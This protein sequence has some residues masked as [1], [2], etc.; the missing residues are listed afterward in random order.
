MIGNDYNKVGMIINH[1]PLC[2]KVISCNRFGTGTINETYLVKTECGCYILQKVND[3]IFGDVELLMQNIRLVLNSFKKDSYPCAEIILTKDG[4]LSY[5]V[6]GTYWR[7]YSYI[8]NTVSYDIVPNEQVAYQYGY[9]LGQLRTQLFKVDAAQL[10]TI[11]PNFHD[12]KKRFCEFLLA[13]RDDLVNRA[14]Q[15]KG[16]IEYIKQQQLFIQNVTTAI[17]NA[18]LKVC[19]IHN[20][21]RINNL[22]FREGEPVCFVDYD[23]ISR[24]LP[25]YDFCDAFRCACSPSTLE[26]SKIEDIIIDLKMIHHFVD[27]YYSSCAQL[28]VSEEVSLWLPTARMLLLENGMRM[29]TDYLNGDKYFKI[30]YG[31]HN[32]DRWKK[33]RHLIELFDQNV[34]SIANLLDKEKNGLT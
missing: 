24:G 17:E 30:N 22:L 12:T 34:E 29:L 7:L 2:G 25:L 9:A 1:F 33:H 3:A 11:I 26:S 31:I 14:S 32:L 18:Q 15:V 19:A 4:N 16:E 27:G 10:C 20:D 6:E 5:N 21:T 8:E 13:V 28:L 23:T